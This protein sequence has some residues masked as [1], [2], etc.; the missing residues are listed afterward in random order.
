MTLTYFNGIDQASPLSA[1][2]GYDHCGQ[3]SSRLI[4]HTN[5]SEFFL[6]EFTTHFISNFNLLRRTRDQLKNKFD[7]NLF[8][9]VRPSLLTVTGSQFSECLHSGEPW[10]ILQTK[11]CSVSGCMKYCISVTQQSEL[12]VMFSKNY[13]IKKDHA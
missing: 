1:G 10:Y 8:R 3:G 12:K 11:H 5:G 6:L 7:K 4:V 9:P 2:V 13:F